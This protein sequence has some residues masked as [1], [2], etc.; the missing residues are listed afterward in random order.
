MGDRASKDEA[1]GFDPRDLV[2]LNSDIG[3][4][5]FVDGFAKTKRV[6]Q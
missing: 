6:R 5:Q 3:L 2:N 1:P 4:D